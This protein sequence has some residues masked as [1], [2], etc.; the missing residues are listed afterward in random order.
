MANDPRLNLFNYAGT[1]LNLNPQQ[2]G[3]AHATQC[4]ST[5]QRLQEGFQQSNSALSGVLGVIG[6]FANLQV[7]SGGGAVGAG[8]TKLVGIS[9]QVRTLGA[10]ALPIA[11]AANG[12]GF[13]LS[14]V[15]IDPN[16]LQTAGSFNPSV[17]NESFATAS[18]VYNQVRQ[19]TF[20]SASIPGV[21]SGLQNGAAMISSL[22]SPNSAVTSPQGSHFGQMCGAKNYAMDLIA[23]APKYKFLFV[24]QFEFDQA[25]QQDASRAFNPAFVIKSST[26]PSVDF[27]YEDVN[28]YNFRTRVAKKTTYQPITM[29]FLD[30]DHNHA[31]Q[32]YTTYLK[33]LSPIANIETEITKLDPLDAYDLAGGGLGFSSPTQPISTGFGNTVGQGYAASIGPLGTNPA[34][35]NALRRITIFHVYRQGRM[36]N[37]MHFY[38][39]KIT[40]MDL[41]DLDMAVSDGTE[42]SLTF[43]YD[44]LF[45]IPGYRIFNDNSQPIYDLQQM[46]NS[47]SPFGVN[48]HNTVNLDGNP[49]DGFGM[50][51]G[52][53]TLFAFS[54]STTPINGGTTT[55][56]GSNLT[57]MASIAPTLSGAGNGIIPNPS[58]AGAAGSLASQVQ[59]PVGSSVNPVGSIVNV[60]PPSIA[61]PDP[62][63]GL[64]PQSANNAPN[65]ANVLANPSVGN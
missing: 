50:A 54:N 63:T 29:K 48:R 8:L 55:A 22:F 56:S 33:L 59:N 47:G 49:K 16:Q 44:S 19:G 20:T 53:D 15:G 3:V 18:Q 46:T 37:V 41:D 58:I 11:A 23:L 2:F 65:I 6:A 1:L 32:F 7:G 51:Y 5:L 57:G 21:F 27:E 40:K 31:F 38:N 26:R 36:M 28:M 60:P 61:I 12:Q 17:A 30:D 14:T 45:I 13:V 10:A 35:I 4:P 34:T 62:I 43:S 39:P 52:Q 64:T 24:V 42:V 25:F 9:N